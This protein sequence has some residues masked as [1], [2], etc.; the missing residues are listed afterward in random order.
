MVE[1]M[2]QN[3]EPE[4][5]ERHP[6]AGS[7]TIYS[8]IER[9]RH[10]FELWVE[11]LLVGWRH[12]FTAMHIVALLI[13]LVLIFVPPFLP[14]PPE[15]ATPWD[16]FTVFVNF[17]L[18]GLWFPLVLISVIFTGR[19]WC[20]LF[21]PQGAISEW[22]SRIGLHRPAPSWMRWEGTPIVSFILITVLGQTLGVRDHP[23]AIMELF[24]GTLIGAAIVGLIYGYRQRVWC[25]HL[26][27]IG[28]L[29]GIFS[30]LGAVHF[31]FPRRRTGEDRYAE[32]GV[33]PT[34]V[35]VR[36]KAESRHC[37]GCFKCVKP[38]AR[39]SV[40]MNLRIPGKEI[41]EISQYSPHFHESLFLFLGTGIA[42]GG[43]LWLAV[44]EYLS[45]RQYIGEWFFDRDW[46]W[47]GESGPS[48]LMSVHPDRG[49]VFTWVD[50]FSIGGFMLTFMT[51]MALLLS[52]FTALSAWISVK[53]GAMRPFKACFLELGYQ[54][55]PVAMISLILGLGAV[56]FNALTWVG[57]D[58][59][60]IGYVKLTIFALAFCW[61]VFLG[62]RILIRQGLVG[63]KRW[64]ALA[65]GI[66]GSVVIG[67]SWNHALF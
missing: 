46:Y 51:A 14:D 55:A 66:C 5:E 7:K 62:D 20:G 52:L 49:E 21:C 57:L 38:K 3:T 32:K 58:K 12:W 19:S 43:F 27:P 54:Y 31:A 35:D 6:N 16:N 61:S 33:C 39:G 13:F 18:W 45:L 22:T 53:L 26:C 24:G 60:Q 65:P 10:K 44:P 23:E 28:L 2:T 8:G 1:T 9:R 59:D 47:V 29:L 25:R 67:L 41:A 50:F 15:Q 30:R 63:F 11:V 48:W 4:L 40:R 36:Y 34:L 42:L 37:I 17:L 64:L 56:L